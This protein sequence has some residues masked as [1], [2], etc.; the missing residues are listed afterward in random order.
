M[1]RTLGRLK[2][3][4]RNGGFTLIELLVVI[5]IIAILAAILFPVFAQ[6]RERAR[7]IACVSNSRQLGL[8]NYMYAEDW[9]E[10]FLP[11]T[12]YDTPASDPMRIW[13][14]MIAPYVRNTGVFLCPSATGAGYAAD[15]SVRGIAPIGYN[16]RAGYDPEGLEAPT[17]TAPL[18]SMDE[19]SRTVLMAD[20]PSGPTSQKYRGYVFDPMNGLQNATDP[21]LST[22]LVADIDLVAGSPLR[23]SQLKPVLCRHFAT[24][25]NQGFASVIFADGHAK[26]YS[27]ASILAQERGANLIWLFR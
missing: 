13:P 6:A 25:S 17:T 9:S 5:A 19:P 16:S 1:E 4:Q 14:A 11:S 22:P 15:W 7:Q 8:A 23:P 26:A 3:P 12:N 20:T 2:L 21:R 27:A 18:A 10:T 24:G